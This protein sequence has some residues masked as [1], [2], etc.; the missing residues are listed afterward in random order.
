MKNLNFEQMEKV[1]GG[2]NWGA[3]VCLVGIGAMVGAP[4]LIPALAEGTAAACASTS[5]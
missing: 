5:W 1:E 2:L 4:E 3:F